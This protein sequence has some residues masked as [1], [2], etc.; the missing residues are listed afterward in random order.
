MFP[1]RIPAFL[2]GML[3]LLAGCTKE[4]SYS[5]RDAH[6][7]L[8]KVNVLRKQGCQCGTEWMPPVSTVVWNDTLALAANDHAA[9]METNDYFSHISLSGTSPVQR[10]LLR[11]FNGQY[12][13]ENIAKGYSTEQ[14]VINAWI[15]SE[16]HCK[17]IMDSG[18]VSM[19][20]ADVQGYWV[21]EL[22]K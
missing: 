6:S 22:G 13:W 20:G 19:G 17:A 5:N 11:G 7:L 10:A 9:D 4:T 16:D 1:Q 18:P 15:K 14:E 2:L 3:W 8:D 21:L 12:V